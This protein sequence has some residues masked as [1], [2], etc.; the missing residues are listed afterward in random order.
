MPYWIFLAASLVELGFEVAISR[1][2]S[3]ALIRKGARDIAPWILPIMSAIYVLMYAG[4]AAEFYFLRDPVSFSW[5]VG[6]LMLYIVAK[7]LK[8]WAISSLGEF[9]TMKVLVV[10]GSTVVTRGPYRYVRHPNYIAVMAEI[11]ATTMAGRC[12]IT[13]VSILVLFSTVLYYRI[14]SEEDALAGHTDYSRSMAARRRFL[15]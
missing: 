13:C 5:L 15:P 6:F 12:W 14:R 8:F 3:A 9:W 7:A 1:R 11:V 10:P 4:S 2:N